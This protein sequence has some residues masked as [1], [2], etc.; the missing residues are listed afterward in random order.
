[1]TGG[2]LNPDPQAGLTAQ[3]NAARERVVAFAVGVPDDGAGDTFEAL[4]HTTAVGLDDDRR[5]QSVAVLGSGDSSFEAASIDPALQPGTDKEHHGMLRTVIVE[6]VVFERGDGKGGVVHG[7]CPLGAEV[8]GHPEM[9]AESAL[10]V[11][12]AANKGGVT[13]PSSKRPSH[14]RRK[15]LPGRMFLRVCATVPNY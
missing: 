4:P 6:H 13:R 9:D 5:E 8:G 14:R 3:I 10:L 12:S 7:R 15:A 11:H 1:M 2:L